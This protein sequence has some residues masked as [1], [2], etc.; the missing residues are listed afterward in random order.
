MDLL[1]LTAGQEFMGF[2][3]AILM[4]GFLY[5]ILIATYVILDSIIF[6]AI[7]KRKESAPERIEKANTVI[8]WFMVA[9]LVGLFGLWVYEKIERRHQDKAFIK[10]VMPKKTNG[11]LD[12]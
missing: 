11:D 5:M 12:F 8:L 10:E 4:F 1:A 9:I 3:M 7:L 2:L 6:C